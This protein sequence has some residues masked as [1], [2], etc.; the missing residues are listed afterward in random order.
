MGGFLL[1]ILLNWIAYKVNPIWLIIILDEIHQEPLLTDLCGYMKRR[2]L[3]EL[4]P[5]AKSFFFE[6]YI[7]FL[8]FFEIRK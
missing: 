3:T 7:N 2:I 1:I 6:L 8:F 5:K 4:V